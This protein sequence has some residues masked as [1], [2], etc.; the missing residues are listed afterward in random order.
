MGGNAFD[1][2]VAKALGEALAENRCLLH[3]E[4]QGFQFGGSLSGQGVVPIFA[5][6][7]TTN[8]T[9]RVRFAIQICYY[10]CGLL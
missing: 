7:G 6:I 3:L 9:L 10:L 4:A 1:S 5:A 2:Q 8:F